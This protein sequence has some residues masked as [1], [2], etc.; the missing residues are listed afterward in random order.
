M[1]MPGKGLQNL[2][3]LLL[4]SLFPMSIS[5][6]D[7]ELAVDSLHVQHFERFWR[8]TLFVSEEPDYAIDDSAANGYLTVTMNAFLKDSIDIAEESELEVVALQNED[9][10]IF[11]FAMDTS[12]K[13]DAFYFRQGGKLI[14]DFYPGDKAADGRKFYDRAQKAMAA[15]DTSRALMEFSFAVAAGDHRE[16][17]LLARSAIETKQQESVPA[18][19]EIATIDT[20]VSPPAES[21]PDTVDS[22]PALAVEDTAVVDSAGI[23]ELIPPADTEDAVMTVEIP[24]VTQA[25]SLEF[26]TKRFTAD[27][28]SFTG[29][30][31]FWL[32][33]V[34]APVFLLYLY[35][36]LRRAFIR[37]KPVRKKAKK[38]SG[39][40]GVTE[41][42]YDEIM[43]D[44][45]SEPEEGSA[46]SEDDSL[47][48][49]AGSDKG[50]PFEKWLKSGQGR[51][52]KKRG[53]TSAVHT[54]LQS[55][56]PMSASDQQARLES[57]LRL[58]IRDMALQGLSVREIARAKKL[59]VGEVE[60]ILGFDQSGM[61]G[62]SNNKQDIDIDF[63]Y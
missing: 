29:A 49:L 42:R 1:L 7:R 43:I 39:K 4:L 24:H 30:Y 57:G 60:L 25:G 48:I 16:D 20:L 54:A 52:R 18:P 3:F 44:V 62:H 35:S 21:A 32:I 11:R 41:R 50:G 40:K 10:Q 56:P 36:L 27:V 23:A 38:A 45:P 2:I 47:D 19:L 37:R 34:L 13:Y 14:L 28:I 26:F 33:S 12:F 8:A 63:S 22:S 31:K 9:Q 5:A 15:G 51:K 6:Q 58:E 55:D 59:G 17:A 61:D 53:R 46:K